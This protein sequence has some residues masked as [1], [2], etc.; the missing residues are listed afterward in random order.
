MG[1]V[2]MKS[3]SM[4]RLKSGPV[5]AMDSLYP[6]ASFQAIHAASMYGFQCYS[7][8]LYISFRKLKLTWLLSNHLT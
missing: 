7:G 4:S 5:P 2:Y 6:S 8:C 3:E 1:L